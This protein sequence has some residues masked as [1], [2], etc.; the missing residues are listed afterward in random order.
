[1]KRIILTAAA[2]LVLA[3]CGDGGSSP[4]SADESV[5]ALSGSGLPNLYVHTILPQRDA[6]GV[7]KVRIRICNNGT[8][9]AGA[10]TTYL[11]HWNGYYFEAFDLYTTNLAWGWCTWTTSPALFDN[12]PSL[13]YTHSYYVWADDFQVV[14]ESNENDNHGRL[15]SVQ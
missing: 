2:A 1:M 9:S 5:P 12:E 8:A 14:T 4:V 13:G 3:G 7:L 6:N 11:E 15:E 10:S